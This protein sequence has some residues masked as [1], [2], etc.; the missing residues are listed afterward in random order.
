[1]NTSTIDY[2]RFRNLSGT[3]LA[4]YIGDDW[5]TRPLGTAFLDLCL[6]EIERFDEYHLVYAIELGALHDPER[7]SRLIPKYLADKRTSVWT[8][9]F[10][11]L[12]RIPSITSEVYKDI[13]MYAARCADHELTDFLEDMRCKVR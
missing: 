13:V 5:C 7:F 12:C 1:M 9:A 11:A 3:D 4:A 10:R 8:A 6:T 2:A